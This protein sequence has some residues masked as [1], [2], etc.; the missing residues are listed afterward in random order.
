MFC[1]AETVSDVGGSLG[2]ASF[3]L[4]AWHSRM[5][6]FSSAKAWLAMAPGQLWS[7]TALSSNVRFYGSPLHSCSVGKD[8]F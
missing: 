2:G 1:K 6:R 4:N 8:Y 3:M 5:T 7:G